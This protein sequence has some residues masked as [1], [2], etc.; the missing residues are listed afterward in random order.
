MNLNL[1]YMIKEGKMNTELF[2]KKNPD[3]V[4]SILIE[5]YYQSWGI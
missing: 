2:K 5:M 1:W 3:K 4:E